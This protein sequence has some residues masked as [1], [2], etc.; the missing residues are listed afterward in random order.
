MLLPFL[1]KD[2][3]SG[4]SDEIEKCK[5]DRK[6]MVVIMMAM[7]IR[8]PGSALG[9]NAMVPLLL[10]SDDSSNADIIDFQ[11]YYQNPQC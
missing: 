9:A 11:Q 7:Q 8:A 1:M 10:M 3:D 2:C 4:T 5:K 6:D